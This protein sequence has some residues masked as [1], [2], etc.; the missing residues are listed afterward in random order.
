[1]KNGILEIDHLLTKVVCPGLAGEHFERLGFTVTPLSQIA[2][3]GLCNRLVL[4]KPL[5]AGSANFIELMGITDAAR[6]PPSMAELLQGPPGIRSMVMATPDAHAARAEL[7][8]NGYSVSEVHHIARQ[9]VVPDQILE[10]EF[11][12]LLPVPAPFS[13]NVCRYFSLQHYIR[14]EW[15]QHANGIAHFEAVYCIASD[16]MQALQYYE[17]LFG[18]VATGSEAQGWSVTP[19]NVQLTVFS[20]QGWE[21]RFG[22]TAKTGFAGYRLSSINLA[23]TAEFMQNAGGEV[24]FESGDG[25]FIKSELMFGCFAHICS[26]S[27]LKSSA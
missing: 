16:P 2:S 25:L 8:R 5:T 21:R 19:A 22:T 14:P 10:V 7:V 12:V 9:W 1:M 11:D 13:F 20:H 15:T 24:H 27:K 3:M 23:V 18:V 4:F 6:V 17:E 26:T